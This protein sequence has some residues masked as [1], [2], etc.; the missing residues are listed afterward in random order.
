MDK[1][2]SEHLACPRDHTALSLKDNILS[3]EKEH[4]YFMIE[5]I[6]VMLLDDVEQTHSVAT[7][8]LK[9]AYEY[10]SQHNFKNELANKNLIDP[11]VQEFIAATNGIMWRPLIN[12]LKCYPI[13]KLPIND[14]QKGYFLDIGC[15][16]GRWC[17]SAALKDYVPV[18]IDPS[19]DAI[20]A[21]KRVAKQL[22]ITA[23]FIVADAR[24]LPFKE[25]SFDF[26][27]SYSVLQHLE[28]EGV[29]SCLKE[30]CRILKISG[31]SLIQ[32][33]NKFG[34]RNMFNQIKHCLRKAY[35]FDVKYWSISELSIAFRSNIGSTNIFADGFLNLNPDTA[36]VN[37]LPVYYRIVVYLS[38]ILR[39][40][41]KKFTF[42][43]NIADSVYVKSISTKVV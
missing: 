32:M 41:S 22:G 4:K 7:E 25:N 26:V 36:N 39:K 29:K 23:H 30:I 33:P 27:F 37:L 28:K 16:W 20:M 5:N 15:N 8:S 43:I 17:I 24:Y 6:P 10:H 40:L 9:A 14:I 21:A 11:Y 38:E 35:V 18:G 19:L 13:P 42:L 1:W 12:K 3:C 34:L 31:T 2:V